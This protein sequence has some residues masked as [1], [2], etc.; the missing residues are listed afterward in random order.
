MT[1]PIMS[2]TNLVKAFEI[3]GIK[4][5]KLTAV[6]DVSFEIFEG[7]VLGVVGESGCGKSTLGNMLADLF[8]AT[9]GEIT[10]HLQSDKRLKR[11]EIQMIFQDP[12]ASLNPKKK[13][14]WLLEEPLAIHQKLTKKEREA[15][16]EEMLEIV[17]LDK[18]YKNVYPRE[19]SG[20][21]RQRV[22]IAI[23]LMLNPKLIIADEVV[24]ALDISIQAQIL[25][26]MK[27]LQEK[28]KLTYV[29]IS[30]DLNVV[31]YLST[32]IAVMYLGR[33]VEIGDVKEVY[34]NPS[35]PY[36][37]AL[38]SSIPEIEENAGKEK[39]I[40]EGEVPNPINPPTGCAFHPRCSKASE[41]C[42]EKCPQLVANGEKRQVACHHI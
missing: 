42:K 7:E 11:K 26:L 10:Y 17:G 24:S 38:L 9:Q 16:V 5:E 30:H 6:N 18:A 1:K 14:G 25:N 37:I 40:L 36:T 8:P 2:V 13:I 23:A 41:I 28:H 21:Q 34:E 29:F 27:E 3:N 31:Y 39:I 15:K 22:S 33:I 4:K 12:Y 19:L 32:R 20:G 35:H